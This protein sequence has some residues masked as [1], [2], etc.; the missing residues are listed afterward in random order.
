MLFVTWLCRCSFTTKVVSISPS[1]ESEPA[2]WLVLASKMQWYWGRATFERR[3]QEAN[4][5]P[6][7]LSNLCHYCENMLGL[8]YC[9][10]GDRWQLRSAESQLTP[11]PTAP[12]H[13]SEPSK[14]NRAAFLTAPE[15]WAISTSC[16]ML[17][18]FCGCYAALLWQQ[19]T[20]TACK[21]IPKEKLTVLNRNNNVPGF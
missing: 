18:G 12:T 17:L 6:L 13:V 14:I 5:F 2:L 21:L 16:C 3:T 20:D 4:V 19:I 15:R 1:L 9:R 10:M 7:T 8:A 11:T